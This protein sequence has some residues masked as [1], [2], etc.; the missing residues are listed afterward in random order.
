MSV[1]GPG[2]L[3]LPPLLGQVFSPPPPLLFSVF[4]ILLPLSADLFAL[5]IYGLP[6]PPKT[7]PGFGYGCGPASASGFLAFT[8]LP[9]RHL[10]TQQLPISILNF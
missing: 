1:T 6:A 8:G 5:F 2:R 7:C 4:S 3:H 10:S 9:F